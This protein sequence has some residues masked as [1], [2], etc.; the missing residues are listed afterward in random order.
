MTEDDRLHAILPPPVLASF[1][2]VTG[3][4]DVEL[5]A[6]F[7]GWSKL[8][9]LSEDVVYLF[10]RRGRDDGLRFDAEVCGVLSERGVECAPRV[11][12][13]WAHFAEYAGPCVGFERRHGH[14]WSDIEESAS[15]DE[16]RTMLRSL[17]RTIATWHSLDVS[18]LPPALQRPPEFDTKPTLNYLLGPNYEE[19]V[20]EAATRAGAIRTVRDAWLSRVEEVVAMDGVFVHGDICENQLIVD[21][22]RNVHTVI[23]WDTAG[24]GHPLHDF[25]FGEWGFGIY[26]WERRFPSLRADMWASYVAERQNT[27]MPDSAAVNLVFAIAEFTHFAR[28]RDAG[29]VDPWRARRLANCEAALLGG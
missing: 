1:R 28:Y 20:D 16:V 10:P 17:G 11:V 18:A 12:G 9:L 13:T 8:A 27:T 19:I 21:D 29:M 6:R 2:E 22:D 15:I 23:D 25:D 26:R 4:G 7:D 3:A 5:R 14:Q 24:T